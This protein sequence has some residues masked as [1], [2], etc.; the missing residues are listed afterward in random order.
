M[1]FPGIIKGSDF[2]TSFSKLY[3]NSF[4]FRFTFHK[5]SCMLLLHFFPF[6]LSSSHHL[7]VLL[8]AAVT[9]TSPLTQGL[10]S[11]MEGEDSCSQPQDF[12]INTTFFID[13]LLAPGLSITKVLVSVVGGQG[14]NRQPAHLKNLN[15]L[16]NN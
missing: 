16:T 8:V 13:T 2:I 4:F 14:P 7:L 9:F 5:Q 3:N 6:L 1:G 11:Y 15:K 12:E 10:V